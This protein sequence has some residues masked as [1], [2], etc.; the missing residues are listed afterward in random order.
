VYAGQDG[1]VYRKE[2]R[3][4]WEKYDNGNWGWVD[5]PQGG[6]RA[7]QARENAGANAGSRQGATA[8]TTNTSTPRVDSGTKGQLE[9]DGAQRS[10]GS[11]RTGDLG[12]YRGSGSGSS[13]YRPSGGSRSS[14]AVACAQVAAADVAVRDST[15]Q[16]RIIGP[17]CV[18]RS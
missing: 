13:T 6:D 3:R 12:T 9:R 18:A 8:G 15:T 5:T 2:L 4:R 10:T 17:R 1:N 14:A 16:C 7:A 11:Q